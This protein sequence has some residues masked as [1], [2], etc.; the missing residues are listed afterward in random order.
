[1]SYGTYCRLNVPVGA[2][3]RDVIRAA[4]L[5]I[6]ERYRRDPEKRKQRKVFYRKMLAYHDRSLDLAARS[7]L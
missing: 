2:S 6:V 4:R 1:M 3:G 7:R 5:M